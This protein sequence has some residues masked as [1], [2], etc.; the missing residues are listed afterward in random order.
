MPIYET[1]SKRQQKLKNQGMPTLYQFDILPNPF[2]IQVIHIW[3]SAL[4][5]GEENMKTNQFSPALTPFEFAWRL[6]HDTIAR[7][8]GVFSLGPGNSPQFMKCE[9]F[10][11]NT[12][13]E[14]ALDI[15]ELS[16]R[17]ID[18]TMRSRSLDFMDRIKVSQEPDDA[19]LELNHR[20][21]EHGIGYQFMGGQL[22][23]V[24][25][26]Y[27]H[28]QVVEPALLL[29]HAQGFQGPEDEFVRAHEHYRHGKNKEAIVEALKAF[30]S[31][32]KAICDERQW[33]Y[34]STGTAKDLINVLLTEG[35]IPSYLQS[36]FTSLRTILESGLPTVRNKTSGHGQGSSP[37]T[38]P[39]HLAAYA[40]HLAA[41]NIVFLVQSHKALK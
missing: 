16:F 39:D 2:R 34:S 41:T 21:L 3:H 14:G 33:Q 9:Y 36:Q 30:E 25:S 38:V 22:V 31:T 7:E 35:L 28:S 24:D 4:G 32:M 26:Q 20:F 37:V 15:I 12:D 5:S 17:V 1:F 13:I 27:I 8:I 40:L 19:I 11:L 10:L 29:L 6:I 23:R 18:T